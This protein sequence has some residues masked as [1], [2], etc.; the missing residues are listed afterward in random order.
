VREAADAAR[1]RAAPSV[2][3]KAVLPATETRG[4]GAIVANEAIKNVAMSRVR[5]IVIYP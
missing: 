3:A 4:A 2:T 1:V 5:I